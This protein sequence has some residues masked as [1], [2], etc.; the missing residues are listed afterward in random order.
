MSEKPNAKV[1]IFRYDPSIDK[2]PTY[3]EYEVPY[4]HWHNLKV[5]DVLRYIYETFDGSLAF[6]ES[7]YQQLCGS[8]IINLNGKPALACDRFA[9]QEMLIE[10]L[11][12]RKVIKDLVVEL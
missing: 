10:P 6:R 5:L 3:Q 1:K 7:C 11:P 12:K 2:E 9:E 8:C 4:E